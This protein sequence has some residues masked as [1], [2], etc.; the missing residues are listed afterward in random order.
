M[1]INYCLIAHPRS[2]STYLRFIISFLL[3]TYAMQPNHN[4][5]S[6]FKNWPPNLENKKSIHFRKYHNIREYRIKQSFLTK[7]SKIT[8]H[9]IIIRNPISNIKTN[10]KYDNKFPE[11]LHKT[12]HYKNY[13]N[14]IKFIDDLDENILVISYHN[15]TSGDTTL[16]FKEIAKMIKFFDLSEDAIKN[17]EYEKIK[18]LS[19]NLYPR[20][21]NVDTW[22]DTKELYDLCKKKIDKLKNEELKQILYYELDQDI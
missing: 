15:L 8:K 19:K 21:E 1:K 13:W 18:L 12:R 17:Y 14:N 10:C 22:F 2:G 20:K 9:I 6:T 11:Q 5:D 3:K 4:N 16:H 7:H